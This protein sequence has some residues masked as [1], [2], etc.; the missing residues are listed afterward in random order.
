MLPSHHECFFFFFPF[1]FFFLLPSTSPLLFSHQPGQKDEATSFP[2]LI[3]LLLL[4]PPSR[5]KVCLS[6]NWLWLRISLSSSTG[7]HT[8]FTVK[9]K[10]VLVALLLNSASFELLLSGVIYLWQER[11]SG[12]C[13]QQVEYWE[14][15]VAA[16]LAP[17]SSVVKWSEKYRQRFWLRWSD[18]SQQVGKRGLT[19]RCVS[20]KN[21]ILLP[22]LSFVRL[23]VI[24]PR[25]KSF[26]VMKLWI[27]CTI[28]IRE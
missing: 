28:W 11:L 8:S 12:G 17:K 24:S 16:M 26:S 14:C 3:L 27:K 19:F 1:F 25:A 4:S 21:V 23:D 13:T 5:R 18:I 6:L 22:L 15:S 9:T 10:R 7:P 20:S 2:L